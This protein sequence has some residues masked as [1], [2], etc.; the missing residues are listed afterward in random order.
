MKQKLQKLIAAKESQLAEIKTRSQASEDVKELRGL[1]EDIDKIVA[2][3]NELKT[4]YGEMDEPQTEETQPNDERKFNVLETMNKRSQEIEVVSKYATE[5]YRNAFMK[6]LQGKKL[7]DVEARSID[8]GDVGA[9]LP[10]QTQNSIITKLKE[11]APLLNEIELLQVTGNVTFAVEGTVNGADLHAENASIT[12]AS[13]TLVS[14]TLGGYEIVKMVRIS[15]T[16]RTM[17]VNAFETWL[18]DMLSERIALAIEKYIVNGTGNS[19]PKGVAAIAYTAGTNGVEWSGTGNKPTAAN[20]FELI[21][22]LASRHARKAKF[23]MNRKTFW[24]FIMPLRDDSKSPLVKG[25]GAGNYNLIGYPILLSDEVNDGDVFFGNFKMVVANL[26]QAI[27]VKASEHSGFSYNAIDYR[28]TCIFD[29]D[30]ADDA[31]FVKGSTPA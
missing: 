2:E 12:A 27:N 7:S 28:G 30:I 22:L 11:T 16:V 8:T 1:N 26:A 9:V 18:V 29:C 14:V 21:S 6:R 25:E 17:S 23:L 20:L 3:L 15:E 31:A 10:T 5:E 24:Q 4:M 19:Q 13:D